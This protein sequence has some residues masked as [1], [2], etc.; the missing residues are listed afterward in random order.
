MRLLG[1]L[2][3]EK[4]LKTPRLLDATS[5]LWQGHREATELRTDALARGEG[6]LD[7]MIDAGIFN[8]GVA[9]L[10]REVACEGVGRQGRFFL[11]QKFLDNVL[12]RIGLVVWGMERVEE[13]R[14]VEMGAFDE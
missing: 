12:D 9:G 3:E 11:K 7:P 4:W 2:S 1:K 6:L 8:T 14:T 5:L 13:R 10:D